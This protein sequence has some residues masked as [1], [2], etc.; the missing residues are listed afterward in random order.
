MSP[1][2]DAQTRLTASTAPLAHLS[3]D[4]AG[5]TQES[6]EDSPVAMA[7]DDLP[8][9]DPGHELPVLLAD[10]PEI[11]RTTRWGRWTPAPSPRPSSPGWRR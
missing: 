11:P 1:Q 4:G 5:E 2:L 7:A 8:Y 6:R 9:D 3:A 10:L